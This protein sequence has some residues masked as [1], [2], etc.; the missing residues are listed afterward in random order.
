MLFHLTFSTFILFFSTLSFAQSS[1]Y[2]T[3][4]EDV[5]FNSS[6]KV[7]IDEKT[8][9]ESKAPDLI[10]LITTQANVTL[11]N[12]NF[13]PPQLFLRGGESSHI[14]IMIDGV[15]VYDVSWAQRTMNLNS[16]DISNVRRI[17]IIKGGQTVLH[18]GQALAGVIKI[19]TFGSQ[20]KNEKKVMLTSSLTEYTDNQLGL[21]YETQTSENSGLIVSGRIA[22]GKNQS[23]VL[24]SSKKY[25][26]E[27]QNLD[28]NYEKKG[29]TT[30]RARGFYFKDKSTNPT[31][32]PTFINGQPGQSI[33]DSDIERQDD[34]V[35]AS[36]QLSFN[37]VAFKPRLALFGQRG[38]RYYYSSPSSNDVDAKFRSQLQGALL[39]LTPYESPLLK[40]STGLSYMKEDFFLDDSQATLSPAPRQADAFS[41]LKGAYVMSKLSLLESLLFEAGARIE[42]ASGFTE[43]NSYQLGLILFKNTKLEWVTGYRAPSA[44]QIKGVFPNPDLEPE[45][46]QTYSITQDVA[47]GSQ[48]EIS[49]T[50]FETSFDNYIEAR[51][52][53]GGI[54]QYQNTAKVKTR[55][56]EVSSSYILNLKQSVQASYAYQEPWDQVRH[57]QLRRRPKVSGSLRFFQNEEHTTWMLEGSGAGQRNDF[58]A[59]SRYEF[60]GYFLVNAAVTYKYR[61]NTTIALRGSNLLD[62]RPEISIDYYGEGRH[63]WLS[64]EIKF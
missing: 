49:T 9:R 63:A 29:A 34:Q 60:P 12:N 35:G 62:F 40:L 18:G 22:E 39:D 23:P 53:G 13:Q 24:D 19:E 56:V 50:L 55:G 36:A 43:K 7:V 1:D 30:F 4:V 38:W 25:N 51:S 3:V 2:E 54:L 21:S 47:L 17:E 28:L 42:K 61:E 8:I 31:T 41:E 15:P 52:I 26:Q 37:E 57:E 11:F 46:S 6:S 59:T 32:I 5:I 45:T 33:E 20:Y 48:G 10:S 16:L 58:F 44:G 14:L 64:L 27:N